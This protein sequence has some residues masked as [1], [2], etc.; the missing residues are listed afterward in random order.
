[1]FLL[2]ASPLS[3]V[4][5][6][7]AE[8]HNYPQTTET[9]S[10][11]VRKSSNKDHVDVVTGSMAT[12]GLN[13]R[14]GRAISGR[15]N[16]AVD[17]DDYTKTTGNAPDLRGGLHADGGGG[18]LLGDSKREVMTPASVGTASTTRNITSDAAAHSYR[19]GTCDPT[20]RMVNGHDVESRRAQAQVAISAY[21]ASDEQDAE[22]TAVDMEAYLFQRRPI[23]PVQRSKDDFE[24]PPPSL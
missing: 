4:H 8:E 2:R 23:G 19:R 20:H 17:A 12:D 24:H 3:S 14:A 21:L 15:N 18:E 9:F 6:S 22:R 16:A 7:D 10:F 1:M 5:S 11:V 13:S